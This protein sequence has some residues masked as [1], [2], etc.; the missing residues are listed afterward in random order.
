[1]NNEKYFVEIDGE[2]VTETD[3]NKYFTSGKAFVGI[4]NN[5]RF[6]DHSKELINSF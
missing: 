5:G 6:L 2:G 3:E 4:L 1:M